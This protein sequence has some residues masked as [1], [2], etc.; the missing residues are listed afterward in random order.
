MS[1]KAATKSAKKSTTIG[2]S[3]KQ[4]FTCL[5]CKHEFKI[6]LNVSDFM[7]KH[8]KSNDKCHKAIPKCVCRK[9]FY[10]KIT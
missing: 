6:C 7:K 3:S 2:S 10:N 5:G 4:T 8:P 1:D 9:I